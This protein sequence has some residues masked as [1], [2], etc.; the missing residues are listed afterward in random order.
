M[1][2]LTPAAGSRLMVTTSLSLVEEAGQVGVGVS[3]A[4]LM[5]QLLVGW[6]GGRGLGV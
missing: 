2:L 1:K 6:A 4:T 5:S 3:A